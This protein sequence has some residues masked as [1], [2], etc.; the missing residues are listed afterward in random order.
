MSVLTLSC[1][2]IERWYAICHPLKFRSTPSR[3]KLMI[4]IIWC[5]ALCLLV[6]ELIV[7]DTLSRHKG[8]TVLMTTC[9]PMRWSDSHQEAY[10]LFIIIG[11][12]VCPLLLM[13]V[14]YVQIARCL[15]SNFIP[16]ETSKYNVLFVC[17]F[18]CL[19][20]S[21]FLNSFLSYLFS[22]QISFFL[23]SFSLNFLL[24][25]FPSK[26]IS[27]SISFFHLFLNNSFPLF[28]HASLRTVYSDH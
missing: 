24:S 2:S 22:F 12:Y 5:L 4:C 25:K 16:T 15:W 1:I 10:Q 18:V 11:L 3:A 14:T 20:L 27:F 19:F 23:N 21:R 26:F 17:L 7:L 13:F 28:F 6:P 8:L 9:K